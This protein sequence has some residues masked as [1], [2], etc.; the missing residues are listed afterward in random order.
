MRGRA[1]ALTVGAVGLFQIVYLL[2]GAQWGPLGYLVST[3]FSGFGA[4]WIW[5]MEDRLQDRDEWNEDLEEARETINHLRYMLTMQQ[6]CGACRSH[7]DGLC[8]RHS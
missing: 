8:D 3:F 6:A 4:A 5:V 1:T 2:L 7:P